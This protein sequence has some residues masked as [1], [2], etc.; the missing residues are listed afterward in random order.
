M[1]RPGVPGTPRGISAPRKGSQRGE[2]P[3]LGKVLSPGNGRCSEK[4]SIRYHPEIG[5]TCGVSGIRS[6]H[7]SPG[8]FH[9]CRRIN[10]CSRH[11]AHKPSATLVAASRQI[12]KKPALQAANAAQKDARRNTSRKGRDLCAAGAACRETTGNAVCNGRKGEV[13]GERGKGSF[14]RNACPAGDGK[15]TCQQ[16]R[17][18]REH[19]NPG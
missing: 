7:A 2:R 18:I 3:R 17:P 8:Y 10:R 19:A 1:A 11:D 9:I 15:V 4:F 14:H 13:S 6:I 16:A 5:S 12:Q